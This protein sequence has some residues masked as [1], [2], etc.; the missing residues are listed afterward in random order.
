MKVPVLRALVL[1]ALC[2]AVVAPSTAALAPPSDR[3]SSAVDLPLRTGSPYTMC[4]T[5]AATRQLADA[6]M[7]LE[8]VAPVTLTTTDGHRCLHWTLDGGRLESDLSGLG[9]VSEGGFALRKGNQRAEFTHLVAS[10]ILG[11]TDVRATTEH[12][13][14]TMPT[15]SSPASTVKLSP[16]DGIGADNVPSNLAP[17]ATRAITTAIPASPLTPGQ[18][19]FTTNAHIPLAPA[20]P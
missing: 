17:E 7:E 5:D 13:G 16:T 1:A 6:G 3:P 4:L 12:L 11:D 8:A 9:A 20:L 10:L 2:T 19:L 18:Q 15:L 14:R